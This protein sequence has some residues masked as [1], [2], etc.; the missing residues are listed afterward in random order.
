MT[1]DLVTLIE[2]HRPLI[3]PGVPNALSARM[4]VDVGF[5][6]LY[7]TGAGL[8]NTNLG[9]PDLGFLSLPDLV[10]QVSAISEVV[11]V[12]LVVDADTGFGN[13]V[14]VQHTVRRLERA[15]AAAVQIEDQMSPKKCGHFE[16]KEVVPAEEMV[17]K[18]HAA[19][20]A[21]RSSEFLVVARTDVAATEGIGAAI[22]RAGRY[23]EAGA[24][25]LFVEAPRSTADMR[26]V[27]TEVP[28]VHVAN[29]VEGGLTPAQTRAELDDLGFSIG[30]YANAAMRGAMLGMRRIL[31]HLSEHGDTADAAHLIA[32]WDE[33]QT[34][35]RKSDYDAAEKR[36]A[37]ENY[38]RES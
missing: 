26:R 10:W 4:A 15:G 38:T 34:L 36:Y 12:P 20:D 30:L 3:L 23:A 21:R 32:S 35:V 24:D 27:T 6:A 7:V 9:M 14:N 16:G 33:R 8:T 22:D 2:R 19:V 25:I 18:I 37:A 28:G 17:G 5:E 1:S 11:D 29:I 13:A 31:D